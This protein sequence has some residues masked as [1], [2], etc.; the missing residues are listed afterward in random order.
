MQSQPHAADG[1]ADDGRSPARLSRRTVLGG[2]GAAAV[3][4]CVSSGPETASPFQIGA[5]LPLSQGWEAYGNTM[6]RAVEIG[7]DRLESSELLG[8]REVTV[9]VEDTQVDPQTTRDRASRLL[10]QEDVDVLFGPVSSANRIAMAPLLEEHGT[11]GLYAVEYEGSVAEDYCNPWLFKTAEV[12]IQQI[13]PFVPWLLDE[14]GT[15]F[16]LLGSDYVWPEQMNATTAAVLESA[17]GTVLDEQYVALGEDDFSSIIPRIEDADPDVLFMTLT[18]PSVPSIQEQMQNFGVRGQWIDVGISHGQG[19]L[20]GAP[21]GAVEGV[22]SCHTYMEALDTER[23]R[24]FVREFRDRGE[25]MPIT[26][27]TGTARIAMDLLTAA[28]EAEGETSAEALRSG[29]D[30]VSA[31]TVAGDV[32]IDVDHQATLPTR[33]S[34]VDDARTH[35]PVEHFDAVEPAEFCDGI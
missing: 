32:S 5:V 6:L 1:V 23:N 30:G 13:E 22:V 20:A 34:R 14:Y 2:L 29:L 8:D 11:P 27:L 12:P 33:V 26:F 9:Q 21:A 31:E 35:V 28:I 17:G 10:D 25:A 3:A 24:E 7:A 16:Y 19:L 18:G 15:D 4:G